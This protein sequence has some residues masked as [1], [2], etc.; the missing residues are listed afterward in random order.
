[1]TLRAKSRMLSALLF[2]ALCTIMYVVLRF[3]VVSLL[4]DD[5]RERMLVHLEVAQSMLDEQLSQLTSTVGDWAFWDET[6]RFVDDLNADYPRANLDKATLAN[7]RVHVVAF[8]N[9]AGDVVH[10]QAYDEGF[11][12][13]VP[14]PSGLLEHLKPRWAFCGHMHQYF[15]GEVLWPDGRRTTVACLGRIT[16]LSGTSMQVLDVDAIAPSR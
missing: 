3:T 11:T 1:M 14:P 13:E 6:Y 9:S 2:L 10:L 12:H 5:E 7:L 15:R 16:G 8:V 4:L